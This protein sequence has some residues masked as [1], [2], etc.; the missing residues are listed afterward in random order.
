MKLT[1]LWSFQMVLGYSGRVHKIW[2]PCSPSHPVW[3]VYAWETRIIHL[4]FMIDKHENTHTPHVCDWD[5]SI[6]HTSWIMAN[7]AQISGG[8]CVTH[9]MNRVPLIS[10][11]I[12]LIGTRY[13]PLAGSRRW[14]KNTLFHLCPIGWTSYGVTVF[15]NFIV[16]H[17]VLYSIMLLS[18]WN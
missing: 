13:E 9:T 3:K 1:F 6:I 17:I 18:Y 14:Y 7:R 15:L 16:R 2:T 10:L 5:Q 4:T 11:A 8:Q 12:L